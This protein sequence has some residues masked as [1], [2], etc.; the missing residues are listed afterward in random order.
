M[1]I[2]SEQLRRG[3]CLGKL[4]GPNSQVM[5]NLMHRSNVGRDPFRDTSH[6]LTKGNYGQRGK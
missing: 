1:G 3:G 6:L 5:P 4:L 2:N